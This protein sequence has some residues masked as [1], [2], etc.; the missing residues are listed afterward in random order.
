M[1]KILIYQNAHWKAPY[2]GLFRRLCLKDLLTLLKTKEVLVLLGVRRS[3]KT[4]LFKLIINELL[5]ENIHPQSILY[6]NLDDPYFDNAEVDAKYL[7]KIVEKAEQLTQIQVNYLFLDEI[8]NIKGWEKFV[9]STYDSGIYKK[10]FITGSNSSLLQGDYATLLSGRYIGHSVFPLSFREILLKNDIHDRLSLIDAKAKVLSLLELLVTYGA[11][12]EPVLQSDESLKRKILISYYETILLKDC[13]TQD[14]IRDARLIRELSYYLLS[15][16]SASF[17]Y[18]KLA[19]LLGSNEHTIKDYLRAL[20]DG[21][22]FEEIKSFS[23]SLGA[24]TRLGKK[25]YCVD[26]GLISAVAFSFSGNKGKLFENFVYTELK[27]LGVQELFNFNETKECDFVVKI[28]NHILPV[29][30]CY[31]LNSENR[32]REIQGLQTAMASLKTKT[33]IIITFDQEESNDNIK[34]LPAWKLFSKVQKSEDL[35]DLN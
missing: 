24:Q 17:S 8:Q 7:Y 22:L 34:I 27:K 4:T 14:H 1:E 10:I 25:I 13:I 35:F 2:P 33:G 11:F 16:I 31:E 6:L 20:E 23:Y 18:N 21:F 19:K 9:K 30:V 29:Q 3:G 15:N 12:P 26:N 5:K 32:K 28:S